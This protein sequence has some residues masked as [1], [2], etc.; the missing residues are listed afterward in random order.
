MTSSCDRPAKRVQSSLCIVTGALLVSSCHPASPS[1]PQ[2]PAAQVAGPPETTGQVAPTSQPDVPLPM[3]P[4]PPPAQVGRVR[5]PASGCFQ[6]ASASDVVGAQSDTARLN[7]A[8]Y[9]AELRRQGL[10]TLPLGSKHIELHRGLQGEPNKSVPIPENMIP[11]PQAWSGSA[12]SPKRWE[13]VQTR[14]GLVYRVRR[15]QQAARAKEVVLCGCQQ[16]KCGP[17]GSGCP[18]CGVTTQTVYGP[19]PAGAI[20]KGKLRIP[21]NG[22]TVRVSHEQGACTPQRECPAPPPSMPRGD[23]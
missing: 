21:F 3:P 1:Q 6:D 14:G 19:L 16:Q 15:I 5:V 10:V 13:F 18:A 23:R 7:E 12:T 11:G 8:A 2:N 4:I 20:F 17:Y 9:Q 22:E